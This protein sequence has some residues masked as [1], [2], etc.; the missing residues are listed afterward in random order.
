[1][2]NRTTDPRA[3]QLAKTR[4]QLAHRDVG[5]TADWN[6]FTASEQRLLVEE[7]A[8]FLRAAVE[9][10][11]A[12]TVERPTDEQPAVPDTLS[13]WLYQRFAVIHGAPAWDRLADGD[14]AYWEHHA[15][16]VRRAVSRGGFKAVAPDAA[17]A[18]PAAPLRPV[19]ASSVSESAQS[20]AGASE[21]AP[22]ADAFRAEGSGR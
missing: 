1:M 8:T 19:Q 5:S 6:N 4:Q 3:L 11:I 7:A 13:A 21:G 9:A 20:A 12:P 15:E 22:R 17:S 2:T 18:P 16:A 10:G 14:R